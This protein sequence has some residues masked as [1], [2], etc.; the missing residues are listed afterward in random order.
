MGSG[1]GAVSFED[2]GTK[3]GTEHTHSNTQQALDHIWTWTRTRVIDVI[4]IK[5]AVRKAV[6]FR[7]LQLCKPIVEWYRINHLRKLT[8]IP[9]Y[10]FR[11]IKYDT[12]ERLYLKSSP[13]SPPLVMDIRPHEDFLSAP[14]LSIH[15][16]NIPS[17]SYQS[18]T[19]EELSEI[20]SNS[21]KT[22]SKWRRRRCSAAQDIIRS[23]MKPFSRFSLVYKWDYTAHSDEELGFSYHITR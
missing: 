1:L 9:S 12:I 4:H 11:S 10:K 6:P 7:F 19:S 22:C 3:A 20:S 8:V 16:P 23:A 13:C 5:Q 2:H 14:R 15:E 18:A 21:I 17:N